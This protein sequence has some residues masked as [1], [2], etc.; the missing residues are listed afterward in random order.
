MGAVLA[1][2]LEIVGSHGMAARDYPA[3]LGEIVAGRLDPTRLVT[4]TITLDEAPAALVA[5]TSG[6]APGTTVIT[7]E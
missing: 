5:M 6:S 1:R 3:M 4:R 7:F 2:E